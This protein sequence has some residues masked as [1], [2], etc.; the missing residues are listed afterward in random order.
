MIASGNN[1]QLEFDE[2]EEIFEE[3]EEIW[4]QEDFN[5]LSHILLKNHISLYKNSTFVIEMWTNTLKVKVKNT[6]YQGQHNATTIN[7]L[8]LSWFF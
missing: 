8:F 5:F 7:I 2:E 6:N 3:S 1:V 4:A